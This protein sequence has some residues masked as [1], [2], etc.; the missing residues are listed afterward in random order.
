[1][2]HKPLVSIFYV[3]SYPL[4]VARQRFGKSV[5]VATNAHATRIVELVVSKESRR[6]VLPRTFVSGFRGLEQ[7][8]SQLSSSAD[9][10]DFLYLVVSLESVIV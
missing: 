6:L 2:F 3:Y 8:C 9:A 4:I 7:M 5:T 10:S 1:V